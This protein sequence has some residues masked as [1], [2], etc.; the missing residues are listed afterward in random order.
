[1][2]SP[3]NQPTQSI[4]PK[5]K[6]WVQVKKNWNDNWQTVP[7]L[8]PVNCSST[9]S[10]REAG[11]AVLLF[12]T[13]LIL[14][15]GETTA[16]S[17][18]PINLN[19][20]YSRI[21]IQKQGSAAQ[22]A[23]VGV[24]AEQRMDNKRTDY[25]SGDIEIT[26][27]ELTYLFDRKIINSAWVYR[28]V[29]PTVGAST[30]TTIREVKVVPTFNEKKTH[31]L[32]IFG[33]RSAETHEV[34]PD[35]PEVYVFDI[36]KGHGRWTALEILR[37]LL[38]VFSPEQ[39]KINIVGQYQALE[40][41][42][43]V[44]NFDGMTLWEA[45][46]KLITRKRGLNYHLQISPNNE[47]NLVIRS[48]TEFPISVGNVV[49]PANNNQ[50]S[51]YVPNTYVYSH[52][53][54]TIGFVSSS[55][56]Q[57]SSIVVQSAPI[58][59]CCSFVKAFNTLL[60]DWTDA[61]QTDYLN[62]T[63]STD[64]DDEEVND[65]YRSDAKFNKV[66]THFTV[67]RDWNWVS[68]GTNNSI[69]YNA[70]PIPKD[71][72]EVQFEEYTVP[73]DIEDDVRNFWYGDKQFLRHLP[74]FKG[75]DYSDMAT[76]PPLISDTINVDEE[77]VPF[78]VVIYDGTD[79]EEHEATESVM[80]LDKMSH[81]STDL[82]DVN[83]RPQTDRIGFEISPSPR[84]YLAGQNAF[85]GKPPTQTQPELSYNNLSCTG[86]IETDERQRIKITGAQTANPNVLTITVPSAEYWYIMPETIVGVDGE[87]KT[88][89]FIANKKE[90]R[91]ARNDIDKLRGIAAFAASW[92]RFNRQSVEIVLKQCGLFV[93]LGSFLNS[94]NAVYATG[95][96]GTTITHRR[97]DFEKGITEIKT[98]YAELDFDSFL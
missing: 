13:G 63:G 92:Y 25:A 69:K 78:F 10:T 46:G 8:F 41:I 55:A 12:R 95:P 97:I 86:F 22:V 14:P 67:P 11:N 18:A 16:D 36:L 59:V 50:V 87:N 90:L 89:K 32:G 81:V 58:K 52:L 20:W 9:V 65:I 70:C 85:S 29:T 88:Y 96:V 21:I 17:F 45:I 68:H 53:M 80:M 39:F 64:T 27:Y 28:E 44:F 79:G 73:S 94:V 54:D 37:Y 62:A 66:F 51:F 91:V 3:S 33:N 34:Y 31:G 84:H 38:V 4:L 30:S 42:V 93:P 71:N 1:M 75:I 6:S 60:K 43:E 57:Y 7:Y 82:R 48:E 47:V 24:I 35:F 83:Y 5:T 74:L 26:A 15:E 2:P 19:N 23:W 77:L 49:L 61:K 72:G 56:T 98:G 76:E 40:N